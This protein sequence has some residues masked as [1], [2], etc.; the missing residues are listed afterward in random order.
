MKDIFYSCESGVMVVLLLEDSV[1]DQCRR[2]YYKHGNRSRE[3]VREIIKGN[4]DHR[5]GKVRRAN[6]IRDKFREPSI[7]CLYGA[8]V[9]V[10]TDIWSNHG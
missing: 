4:Q 10:I 7:A 3:T 8:G 2:A 5:A 6:N 9:H 1:V